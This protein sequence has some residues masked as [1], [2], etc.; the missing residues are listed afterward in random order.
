MSLTIYHISAPVYLKLLGILSATLDKAVAHAAKEKY[1][2]EALASARLFPDMWNLAEQVKAATNH[3]VRGSARLA[4]LPIP[5]IHDKVETFEDMQQRIGETI[6]FVKSVDPAAIEA[7]DTREVIF[8]MG[9]EQ[10]KL[11][12]R[13]YFLNFSLPNFYFHLTTA[14][15][16]LRHNGVPLAKDDF[17]GGVTG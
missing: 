4:G 1:P 7:G 8:P 17:M 16:I 3:A 9:D 5:T 11:T 15:N 6:A 10:A 2:P 13:Q 14:Y 12:G